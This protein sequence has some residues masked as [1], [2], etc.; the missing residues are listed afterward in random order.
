MDFV[1]STI[2]VITSCSPRHPIIIYPQVKFCPYTTSSDSFAPIFYLN[3]TAGVESAGSSSSSISSN[4][5]NPKTLNEMVRVR[6]FN[7][8][9]ITLSYG[10]SFDAY[11]V[12]RYV[13]EKKAFTVSFGEYDGGNEGERKGRNLSKVVI[14]KAK[15]RWKIDGKYV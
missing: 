4:V 11:C 8:K 2:S 14:E 3:C 10:P 9:S 13:P 1:Y 7:Y 12:M 15:V 6:S 5:P